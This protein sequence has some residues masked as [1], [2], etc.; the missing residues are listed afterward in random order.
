MKVL[1]ESSLKRANPYMLR[2]DGKLIDCYPLRPYINYYSN[3]SAESAI[4]DTFSTNHI[5]FV[6]WFYDNTAVSTTKRDIK[7]LLKSLLNTDIFSVDKAR[8]QALNIDLSGVDSLCDKFD[9]IAL[10]KAV[11]D[12]TNQEF[13]RV[14]TSSL[15]F[16][17][18][19]NSIYFRV[20]STDFNWFNIIWEFVYNNRNFIDKVTICTDAQSR[21]GSIQFYKHN[22]N[23]INEMPTQEFITLSGN[24][25]IESNNY[26]KRLLCQG[27]SLT[28]AFQDTHPAHIHRQFDILVK[29]YIKNNFTL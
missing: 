26:V 24:P 23:V 14:R 28:E 25:V 29:E 1:K 10:Y 19:S 16:G 9:I 3:Y 12:E 18:T 4:E 22:G 27:A 15:K 13:L 11:N 8:I 5:D 20:S 6:K 17:G 21:G 2:N 7:L